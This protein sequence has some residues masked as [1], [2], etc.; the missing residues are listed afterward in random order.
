MPYGKRYFPRQV[1]SVSFVKCLNT[2]ESDYTV[3]GKV[4]RRDGDFE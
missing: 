3:A 4:L 1:F 2:A